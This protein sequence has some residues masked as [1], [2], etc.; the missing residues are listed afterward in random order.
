MIST[1]YSALVEHDGAE[2]TGSI[3]SASSTG[4]RAENVPSAYD[5][6]FSDRA[7]YLPPRHTT[8][9][10]SPTHDSTDR[11]LCPTVYMHA[12][13]NTPTGIAL[14]KLSTGRFVYVNRSMC[15]IL[16]YSAKELLHMPLANISHPDDAQTEQ[17]WLEAA[18]IEKGELTISYN[19]RLISKAETT[20]WMYIH[21]TVH[22]VQPT[23]EEDDIV[24]VY[25]HQRELDTDKQFSAD[26]AIFGGLLDIAPDAFIVV[27]E[28]QHILRF[29]KGAEAAFGYTKNEVLGRHMEILIPHQY[30]KN[31]HNHVKG[32]H[33]GAEQSRTMGDRAR[34]QALRKNGEVFEAEASVARLHTDNTYYFSVL[35]R[36]ITARVRAEAELRLAK[37]QAETANNTKDT[38]LGIAAHDIKNP[39]SNIQTITSLL[40][41]DTIHT[42]TTR[43]YLSLIQAEAAH[44]FAIVRDVLNLNALDTGTIHYSLERIDVQLPIASAVRNYKLRAA[45]KNITLHC[46]HPTHELPVP[47]MLDYSAIMQVLDNLISNAIKFTPKGSKVTVELSVH[48]T[49]ARISISDEGPGISKEDSERLF[50][51]F[52]RLSAQ[53]TGGENSTGLGLSIVKHIVELLNG[54]IWCESTVG[55]GATFIVELPLAMGSEGA[56]EL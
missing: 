27:D 33:L 51:R 24:A 15:N 55:K 6:A 28:H 42:D 40:L 47:V 46:T 35:L 41:Q 4:Q 37:E 56:V 44:A 14:L 9:Q 31:H 52:A 49:T 32:F 43:E 53:P 39:L 22:C 10:H 3:H 48:D 7:L 30:R 19:K 25:A 12:C 34:I 20:V 36:D 54:S 50:Q 38:F 45:Q 1:F 8:I 13:A 18:K 23:K 17:T 29:N 26:R 2:Q 5:S 21:G 11:A 16:G